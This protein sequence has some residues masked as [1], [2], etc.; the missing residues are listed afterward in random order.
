MLSV[1]DDKGFSAALGVKELETSLTGE[2]HSTSAASLV[3]FD[4][5]RNVIWKAP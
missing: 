1:S 2:T 5:N 3:L 4:K